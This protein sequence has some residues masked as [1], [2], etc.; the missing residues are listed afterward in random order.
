VG[1]T[2]PTGTRTRGMKIGSERHPVD[3]FTE[4]SLGKGEGS[5]TS[6]KETKRGTITKAPLKSKSS[7]QNLQTTRDMFHNQINGG[8]KKAQ[9]EMTTLVRK[10]RAR[11]ATG[12]PQM[13]LKRKW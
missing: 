2:L 13:S 7:E 11:N 12:G 3:G 4:E 5:V 8:E 6:E 1:V 9:G 10:D